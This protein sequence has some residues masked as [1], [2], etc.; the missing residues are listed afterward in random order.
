MSRKPDGPTARTEHVSA[1]FRD[2]TAEMLDK[3]RG[4]GTDNEV[5]RSRHLER[6][7]IEEEKRRKAK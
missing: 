6:L 1:R 2:T 3:Q 7:I 5:P 4:K